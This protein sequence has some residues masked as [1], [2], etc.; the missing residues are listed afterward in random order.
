MFNFYVLNND[1]NDILETYCKA[2]ENGTNTVPIP[3]DFRLL[4]L[5]TFLYECLEGYTTSDEL[6]VLCRPDGELSDEPPTCIGKKL[7]MALRSYI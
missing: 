4:S 1:C 2:L 3:E 7:N 6:V 5:Q